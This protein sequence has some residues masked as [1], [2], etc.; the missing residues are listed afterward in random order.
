MNAGLGKTIQAIASLAIYHD[1]W[2]VLV[3]SPSGARYHWQ[4]EFLNWLGEDN[5]DKVVLDFGN[6]GAQ[7]GEGDLPHDYA[8]FAASPRRQPMPPLRESQINVLTSGNS[9]L[10]PTPDTKVV[11]MSYGLAPKLAEDKKL[12]PGMFPCAIVDESHMLK[13]KNSKRTKE[14]MPVLS[15]TNRCVLLSGTP[16]FARPMEIWPQVKILGSNEESS[17]TNE[18]EFVRKYVKGQTKSRRAELHTLLTGTLMIRRMKSDILKSLPSKLREQALCNVLTEQTKEEF[19]NYLDALKQGK[20]ALA[21]IARKHK[22]ELKDDDNIPSDAPVP[23]KQEV[24]RIRSS[25]EL[26]QQVEEEVQ[27]LFN[28][29]TAEIDQ[30]YANHQQMQQADPNML[31]MARLQSLNGLRADI[32]KF[33]HVRL[34]ELKQENVPSASAGSGDS[35]EPTSR[36]A[37][38]IQMYKKTGQVKIPLVAEMLKLWLDNPA[39][40]KLC[41][42]AHHISVL[43]EIGNIAELSNAKD[44]TKK[45][46]RIDGSTNPKQRQEQINSFQKD[47]SVRIALLGITA[48]GVAV[49][50]TASSTVWFAELFWTPALLV[51]AEDRCHRIGQQARVRCM[52]FVAKGTLDEILWKHVEKKFRDLGEFVEGKEKMRIVVHKKYRGSAELRKSIE[53]DDVDIDDDFDQ[54][55]D[56]MESAEQLENELHDDIEEL[57]REEQ[58]LMKTPDEDDDAEESNPKPNGAKQPTV[59][60]SEVE[61]I[62]LSDDEEEDAI[63]V[64][65][66]LMEEGLKIDREF[67]ELKLYRMRFPAPSC[68]L[69]VALHK[70]RVVVTGKAEG[71]SLGPN[72]KPYVGDLLIAC[73]NE[74]VAPNVRLAP[75]LQHFSNLMGANGSIELMFAEEKEFADYFKANTGKPEFVKDAYMGEA[76]SLNIH[77]SIP[78]LQKYTLTYEGAGDYGFGVEQ[79]NSAIVVTTLNKNRMP[80]IGPEDK[81]QVGDILATINGTTLRAGLTADSV[82]NVLASLK[83]QGSA[84]QMVFAAADDQIATFVASREAAKAKQAA[85]KKANPGGQEVIELLE[86]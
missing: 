46:I 19:R 63:P 73:N 86:D 77:S 78:N 47:P 85:A 5:K 80:A 28:Q 23:P 26:K 84:V 4:N 3:L 15:A 7:G 74:E 31:Q 50:L 27:E 56:E 24:Q 55:P 45:F 58:E 1:E 21:N 65:K 53:V 14:L 13:N 39:K 40:G 29:K 2:P 30:Y 68:G 61:A 34:N 70:G 35:V 20:G 48:A 66:P 69:E 67:P 37:A 9:P 82:K 49:T 52:Y 75:L 60:S 18:D 71:S 12:V 81:P 6:E 64:R 72:H 76:G 8:D 33:Y 59:G 22:A 38:L 11:I 51:Q 54:D 17:L 83:Q 79:V 36:K 44:S 42:F 41:I 57:E 25:E 43:N 32:D 62:C 10:L 16:A